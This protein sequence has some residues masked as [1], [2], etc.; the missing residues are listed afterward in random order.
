M[1][2]LDWI[3]KKAVVK[4]HKDVPYRLLEPVAEL[5]HGDPDSGNL[6]VQG[7]NLHA[8]KALLP[9]YAGK[10][11]CIYI[12]P[13][14]NTG[15]EGCVYNDNV[16]SPEISKWLDEVVGKEG[17]DLSR[18]DKWLCMMY[19]RLTLLKNFL[20]EDGVIMIS[21]DDFEI[22]TLRLLMNEIF[23]AN[24][25]I[26]QI[27]W[28][29]TRKNDARLFSTGHEYL[30]IYAKSL[31]HLRKVKTIWREQKPGAK[32]IIQEWKKFRDEH[33]DDYESIQ[34]NLRA[35][36]KN[37]PKGDP[38]KKLSRYK[39]VDKNGPWRDRDISWPGGGGPRYDVIH[40]VTKKPCKVPERGWGFANQE[41]MG[42]QIRLGLIVFRDD[43]TEPPFRKAH[44]LPI[45][46][47]VDDVG[48]ET[49]I[50]D[51][52]EEQVGLQVMPSVIQKQSQV[53]V[54]T[55]RDIFS[56]EKVFENPKD[57]EILARFI[58]YVTDD[59]DFILD[60]FAGSGS[61]G[62]AVL[63]INKRTNTKRNFILVELNEK[64][65]ETITSERI[66]RVC[67]GY[68]TAKGKDIEGLGSGFQFS[69]LSDEPLFNS[70]GQI[71]GEVTFF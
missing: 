52:N 16:S 4:H 1:P 37:L 40:P 50:S 12:D 36:Y 39:W 31:S 61:T 63:D 68:T 32:E 45:P 67:E 42:E 33:D 51:T 27:V 44:L 38:S 34:E 46:E 15:S 26:A 35:W 53:A 29:K 55:L 30:L 64:I 49:D 5:S 13:P 48:S 47:E 43:H 57:H 18:H 19:P 11:K 20:K 65:A 54:R 60:S 56:G 69:R 25:F 22:H 10:V 14:Y 17:E 8:L 2:T 23:G 62:H 59:G 6:I 58:E 71:H 9:R 3:G 28:D 66:R 70:E 41:V 21:M 24:N 7:D